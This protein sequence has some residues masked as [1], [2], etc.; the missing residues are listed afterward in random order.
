MPD[1]LGETIKGIAGGAATG[2]PLGP[3]GAVAGGL[4]GGLTGYLGARGQKTPEDYQ[5]ELLNKIAE[6]RRK[7]MS[8]VISA[9]QGQLASARQMAARRAA[10]AGLGPSGTEAYMLPAEQQVLGAGSEALTRTGQFYDQAKLAV[11]EQGMALPQAPSFAD[12]LTEI[13]AGALA[14]KQNKD[15]LDALATIY[16]QMRQQGT[17]QETATTSATSQY[18]WMQQVPVTPLSPY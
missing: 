1:Y 18:P 10:A 8:D 3:W 12:Y 9:T 17:P 7:A 11:M 16:R 14:Y 13:G 4:L 6:Y 5:Q 15:Y 2:A